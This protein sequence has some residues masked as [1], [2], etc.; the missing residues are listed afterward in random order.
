MSEKTPCAADGCL[1]LMRLSILRWPPCAAEAIDCKAT[2]S[3]KTL[4]GQRFARCRMS[5]PHVCVICDIHTPRGHSRAP[6]VAASPLMLA[7]STR[8][9]CIRN[10]RSSVVVHSSFVFLHAA[11]AQPAK[12][13]CCTLKTPK[14]S[15]LQRPVCDS[16]SVTKRRVS[17]PCVQPTETVELMVVAPRAYSHQNRQQAQTCELKAWQGLALGVTP[18][19]NPAC[20][21]GC[22]LAYFR[23]AKIIET[24]SVPLRALT[25]HGC[26]SVARNCLIYLTSIV[27]PPRKIATSLSS[28][29]NPAMSINHQAGCP[30]G[31]ALG[32]CLRKRALQQS[33]MR[34]AAP[35]A[36]VPWP[37]NPGHRQQACQHQASLCKHHQLRQPQVCAA[38]S[39]SLAAASDPSPQR[40]KGSASNA[41]PQQRQLDLHADASSTSGKEE[42]PERPD[43]SLFDRLVS[44]VISIMAA[45]LRF[46]KRLLLPQK[47]LKR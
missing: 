44:P 35:H 14:A 45:C 30:P 13:P 5:Y 4:I 15:L 23:S 37:V 19:G 32:N 25:K 39:S 9:T 20:V 31:Q 2:C 40:Q 47:G 7:P 28:Q 46:L 34:R 24:R 26:L 11:A 18:S 12:G 8:V 3:H 22:N 43:K 1:A 27:A 33:G 38:A 16:A 42:E 10:K 21:A 36:A 6:P 17:C 41:L 29:L